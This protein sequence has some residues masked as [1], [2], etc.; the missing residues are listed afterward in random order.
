MLAAVA[1]FPLGAAAQTLTITNGVQTYNALT[2]TTVTMSGHSELHLTTPNNPM[3]GCTIN[4][5]SPDAW[6]LL[7]NIHRSVVYASYLGQFLVNGA[8]AVLNSNIRVVE[9]AMG[10][11]VIPHSPSITPLQ[12]F[13]GPNFLGASTSL[14]LYTYYNT[15]A[16]LGVFNQNI[17]S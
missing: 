13:S 8:S 9:Y 16:A 11:M 10:T 3:A 15:S 6:V 5:T 1:L 14:A 4:L 2:N 12:I 7:P 17:R